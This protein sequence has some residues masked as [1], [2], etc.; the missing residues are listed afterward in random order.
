MKIQKQILKDFHHY[1]GSNLTRFEKV[2]RKV[3]ELILSSKIPDS[4]R[5]DSIVFEFKHASGC[6]Q[7][8]R[9]L[10]Q[11]RKLNTEIADN[12]TTLHDIYVIINGTYKDHAKLGAP[13]AKKLLEEIGG[14]SNKEITIITNAVAHHSEKEIYSNNPYVELVKDVDVFDCSLYK[15]AEGFYRIHKPEYIFKEYVN[16]IKKVREELGL[17]PNDI[18]RI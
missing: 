2:E 12:A 9:I 11:K 18:F 10:A 1:K 4:Q 13:I 16:R 8:A 15:G 5:E 3:I 17:S 14:F 6:T 7:I